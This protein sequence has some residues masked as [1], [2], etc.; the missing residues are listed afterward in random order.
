MKLDVARWLYA[1]GLKSYEAEY[2]R[3]VLVGIVDGSTQL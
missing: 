1:Y 3:N 2:D